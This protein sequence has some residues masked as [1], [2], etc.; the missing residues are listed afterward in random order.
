MPRYCKVC[1]SKQIFVTVDDGVA[2]I[3]KDEACTKGFLLKY[4]A[5]LMKFGIDNL[6]K[7]LFEGA[8]SHDVHVEE[9]KN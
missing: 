9:L 7:N 3:I 5:K 1:D 2:A 4:Q 6:P 8:D